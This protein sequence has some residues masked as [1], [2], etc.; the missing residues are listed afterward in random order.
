MR[1]ACYIYVVIDDGWQSGRVKNGDI[2]ANKKKFT[3][4]I[5]A[6]ADY[7]HSK[8]LKFGIYS[9]KTCQGLPGSKGNEYQDAR[10][11]AK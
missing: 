10:I 9:E 4:G 11:Y 7:I 2:I 6:L 5:N 8:G 1:D 3:S